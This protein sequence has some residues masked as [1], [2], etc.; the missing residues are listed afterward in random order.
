MALVIER[1]YLSTVLELKV[2]IHSFIYSSWFGSE[3]DC[4][5]FNDDGGI[6]SQAKEF[7]LCRCPTRLTGL[8]QQGYFPSSPLRSQ[9][10]FSLDLLRLFRVLHHSAKPTK[11]GF[12]IGLAAFHREI[13]HINQRNYKEH[14]RICLPFFFRTIS[15]AA[16]MR[17]EAVIA[18]GLG[19]AA[20]MR[21]NSLA[22]RCPADFYRVD[23]PNADRPWIIGIDGNQQHWR[24]K[25]ASN[26]SIPP[27]TSSL[28]VHVPEAERATAEVS[29]PITEVCAHNFKAAGSK[30]TS[31]QKCD[32]TGLFAVICR[33]DSPL[34]LMNSYAGER[35]DWIVRLIE[36]FQAAVERET[37]LT[38]RT[39]LTYDVAC[40]MQPYLDTH[41]PELAKKVRVVVNKFHG[42]AHELR[43][44]MV[45]GAIWEMLLAETDGEGPERVWALLKWLVVAGRESS[46]PIRM[47]LLED[48]CDWLALRKRLTLGMLLYQR[49][50]KAIGS[51]RKQD[52]RLATILN[53]TITIKKNLDGEEEVEIVE[54]VLYE[55]YRNQRAYF[56]A[57][58][59]RKL[60]SVEAIYTSIV[61][62]EAC[63]RD[64]KQA[65][66]RLQTLPTAPV[67][68]ELTRLIQQHSARLQEHIHQTDALLERHKQTRENWRF[69]GPLWR[70][71]HRLK[72]PERDVFN[73]LQLEKDALLEADTLTPEALAH[74]LQ[75]LRAV[76]DRLLDAL[77]QT[78]ENWVEDGVLWLR[79]THEEKIKK[80]EV[81]YGEILGVA[82]SRALELRNL[83]AR[84]LGN[85]QAKR[86]LDALVSRYPALRNKIDRFN[87]L[88]QTLPEQYRPPLL[89]K[90]AFEDKNID[91]APETD[92]TE[93][94]W[95]L[96]ML[97][98]DLLDTHSG[99]PKGRWPYSA[100]I[101]FGIDAI[102]RRDRAI[103]E[104][105]LV[106]IEFKRLVSYSCERIA[107]LL[108]CIMTPPIDGYYNPNTFYDWLWEEIQALESI[109]D[110]CPKF[111]D[112]SFLY[113][114]VD[115]LLKESKERLT[116]HWAHLRRARDNPNGDFDPDDIA[117]QLGELDLETFG[118]GTTK[119][120]DD[121]E[122]EEGVLGDVL[123]QL[124]DG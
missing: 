100:K 15:M 16:Q 117:R 112:N 101:R 72:H 28:F 35:F 53:T 23:C 32:E 80:L 106:G 74:K 116:A 82:A 109:S 122:L 84:V 52:A 48:R 13:L 1:K 31:M 10:A 27:Y 38:N 50:K 94:L 76:T 55:E 29:K 102:H 83:K 79:Y 99:V 67:V 85:R 96:E 118:V 21:H 68:A 5:N 123:E 92:G 33:H 103:E 39:L 98:S 46:S 69:D 71:M 42:M 93:A 57:T 107:T 105:E 120:E 59:S 63:K 113:P 14:L 62:E 89:D 88:S 111:G 108:R 51:R 25:H 97:C 58:K 40:R 37:G 2:L 26:N 124:Q 4:G 11:D 12:A 73:N 70:D 43:C 81:L 54:R 3:M 17:S 6:E 78:R 114:R 66:D 36:S 41:H 77:G 34:R 47:L 49:Y 121:D 95:F 64:I 86:V 45:Y 56:K 91:T 61:A 44:Q 30:P 7:T 110:A 19:P 75:G 90:S 87:A 119:L 24:F 104:I 60:K 65:N 18:A 20:V 8:L 9:T 22:Q 115:D